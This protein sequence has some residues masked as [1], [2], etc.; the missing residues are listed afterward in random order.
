MKPRNVSLLF[1]AAG[2][3]MAC[4]G[5]APEEVS[6]AATQESALT[7]CGDAHGPTSYVSSEEACEMAY[8][9]APSFCSNHGG[10]K[11]IRALCLMTDGPPWQGAYYVCC[12]Q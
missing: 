11:S 4:G 7:T 12:N 1:M 8:Q 6:E 10:V 5:P 2:L 9:S 3:M